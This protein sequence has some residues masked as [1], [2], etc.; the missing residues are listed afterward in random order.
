L[1]TRSIGDK[2][3]MSVRRRGKA[4]QVSFPLQPPPEV[5]PRDVTVLQGQHPLSGAKVLNL[6]PA[7]AA[8]VGMDESEIGVLTIDIA[9]G[10]W[11]S[12]IGLRPGDIIVSVNGN[13]IGVVEDLKQATANPSERWLLEIRRGSKMLRVEVG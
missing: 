1:A 2:V 6:S 11:A 12:R 7:V 8:E 5:P 3:A 13:K 10:S 9:R 4:S